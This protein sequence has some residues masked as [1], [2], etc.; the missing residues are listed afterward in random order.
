MHVLWSQYMHVLWGA[1]AFPDPLLSW[2][3]RPW[4][5]VYYHQS[6][7]MYYDHSTYM[8]YAHS[9]CMYYDHSIC[10]YYGGSA[11]SPIPLAFLGGFG[12]G[13]PIIIKV[14]ARTA[15]IAHTCFMIM[16]HACT[17]SQYMHVLKGGL[18]PSQTP[19]FHQSTCVYHDHSTYTKYDHY[20]C[21]YYG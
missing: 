5:P 20:P 21:M 8:Y 13:P 11:S 14:H 18:R 15:I 10:M 1:C 2:G 7:C 6:T 19:C 12:P 4:T 9:T 16:V 17:M 3:I